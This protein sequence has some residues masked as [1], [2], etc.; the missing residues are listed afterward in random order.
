MIEILPTEIYFRSIVINFFILLIITLLNIFITK[1][2]D[3]LFKV[4]KHVSE[5]TL[6]FTL[7]YT[8]EHVSSD[9]FEILSPY[10]IQCT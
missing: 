10:H 6:H 5:L 4:H 3:I 1:M 7:F 8:L 2:S 9:M